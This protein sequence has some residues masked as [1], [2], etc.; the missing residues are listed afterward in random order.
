M[1]ND[2]ASQEIGR[3]LDKCL[4]FQ[5]LPEDGRHSLVARMQQRVFKSREP[6]FHVGAPGQS[7]LVILKGFV[8][9]SLPGPKGKVVILADLGAGEL[10]GEVALFDGKER[11]AD[12]TALTN[13]TVAVLERRDVV[14]FLEKRPDTCLKLM[15][16][17][18]ARLRKSDE[19][20]A[21]IA[22]C[23]L[24]ARLAKVLLDRSGGL[25]SGTAKLSLSQGEL[26]SMINASRENV[27]RCL[28]D[29]QRR[30][31]VSVDE[32]WISVLER[33]TLSS[34]ANYS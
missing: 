27:N 22:F 5:A 29:W 15:E 9:V 32:R 31:I 20:M 10:I 18:C 24:P 12:A 13:C 6:I 25:P 30:G 3:L 19:R 26:A 1:A 33:D 8:R 7:M 11:S 14:A 17:M 34:V 28:R 4:L 21:E 2:V 23:E 16:L